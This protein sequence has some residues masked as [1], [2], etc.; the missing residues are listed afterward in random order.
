MPNHPRLLCI[1]PR[2][3]LT[4]IHFC[5]CWLEG[6]TLMGRGPEASRL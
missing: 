3:K 6:S 4:W 5:N 2:L 1:V